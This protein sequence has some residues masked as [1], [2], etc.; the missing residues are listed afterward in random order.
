MVDTVADQ[1]V[2]AILVLGALLALLA[3]VALFVPDRVAVEAGAPTDAQSRWEGILPATAQTAAWFVLAL[4]LGYGAALLFMSV[5]RFIGPAL[6][7][8]PNDFSRGLTQGASLGVLVAVAVW[9]IPRRLWRI[10]IGLVVGLLTGIVVFRLLFGETAG[11][12]A[13]T[14][15]GV[16]AEIGVLC[17]LMGGLIGAFAGASTTV[18]GRMAWRVVRKTAILGAASGTAL[19]LLGWLLGAF[20]LILPRIAQIPDVQPTGSASEAVLGLLYGVAV[21]ALVGALSG[22]LIGALRALPQ[23]NT[24]LAIAT[25]L[26]LSAG[27][28]LGLMQGFARVYFG[29]PPGAT[30]DTYDPSAG[31]VGWEIGLALALVV[32]LSLRL[33][34]AWLKRRTSWAAS[35]HIV[36]SGALLTSGLAIALSPFALL[37]FFGISI[38]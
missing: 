10:V 8:P 13:E 32:G 33:L 34:D 16:G 25:V 26:T 15:L 17:V 38:K 30:P 11:F 31:M 22:A 36:T 5:Q 29:G 12:G 35:T 27:L 24:S 19:A 23:W 1:R 3:V 7:A 2:S 9:R 14:G 37:P 18:H 20:Q 4:T 28:Y 6:L 21:F